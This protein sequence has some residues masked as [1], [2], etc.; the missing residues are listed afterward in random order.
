MLLSPPGLVLMLQLAADKA[1]D[2]SP[3]PATR[4]PKVPQIKSLAWLDKLLAL[5]ILLAMGIG[6]ILGYFVPSTEE[7]LDKI[8]FVDVSLPLGTP[9]ALIRDTTCSTIL[10]TKPLP[11]SS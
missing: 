7:V 1:L 3:D 6:I 10:H 5:W 2:V 9:S 8:K 4:S 11:S